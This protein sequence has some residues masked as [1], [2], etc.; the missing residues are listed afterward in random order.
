MSVPFLRHGVPL[1]LLPALVLAVGCASIQAVPAD[2]NVPVRDAPPADPEQPHPAPPP[3][4]AP[5][6]PA[7]ETT[8]VPL[9]INL[10]TALQLAGVNP[11]D[12]AVASERV[13]AATAQLD[14]A[15]VAW[16]PTLYLGV[17]YARQDGQ[18][19]DIRGNV[20]TTSRSSFMA[21]AGPSMTFA[22]TD[23]IYSPLAA[24]QVLKA[25]QADVQ[26]ALNDTMYSV[27]EAYFNV[28]QARGEL[29]GAVDAVKRAED[30]VKRTEQ[31]APGVAPAVETNRARSDLSRRRQAVEAA[32]DRWQTASAD[33]TRLLRLAPTAIVEPVEQP[34]SRVELVD[35]NTPVDDLI[36]A[37][38][39]HRPELAGRQALVQATLVRLK[40]EKVRPLV[41]SVLIRGNATNPAGTLSSGVFG[42]GVNDNLSNFGGRNSIDMQL[43]WEFQNL[44]LGNRAAVRERQSENQLAVLEVFRVQDRIAAEVVQAHAQAQRA[45]KR[46]NEAEAGLRE[47]ADTADKSVKSMGETK[48]VGE[49]LVLVFRPQEVVAAVQ[50]LAQAYDDYFR[51]VAD[52]NRAQFR[53]YRALGHPAQCVVRVDQV[54]AL[55][56]PADPTTPPPGTARD[57]AQPRRLTPDGPR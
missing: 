22:V 55:Q 47:A 57:L 45:T 20:F 6:V 8:G 26:T 14:R 28:Q 3:L 12:V 52:A 35:L 34:Q 42:G 15:N 41:P 31:L 16:L 38:L 17:D 46:L 32:Y 53:L 40:Q 49:S 56:R 43:V 29:A 37:A 13:K 33:L 24:K 39:V 1:L 18:I 9:P 36:P 44:G 2:S 48:R 25:R 10:P 19:Q 4:P 11:I 27:A 51:A 23:A 30:V 50:A 54:P 21:G 7:A 5:P